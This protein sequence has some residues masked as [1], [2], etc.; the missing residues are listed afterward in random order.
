MNYSVDLDYAVKMD[1]Q[2]PLAAFRDEFYIPRFEGN[3]S[4]QALYFCGNSL[5]LQP[6]CTSEYVNEVLEQW[7]Q[8]GVKGHFEGPYPWLP[9]HELLAEPLAKLVGAKTEEVVAMNSLTTNL[10]LMMVSFFQ[11]TSLRNKIVIEQHAFPSDNYAVASQ[12]I[13]HKLDPASHLITL[14][15]RDD[16]L[17]YTEDVLQLLEQ[18]GDQIVL[19]LLPGI[20]YYTGQRLDLEVITKAAHEKGCLVGADLAHA[21]GNTPLEL[22]QWQVD[23]AVWCH[24]KYLN[25]GPGAVGGCFIHQRHAENKSL[26]RF[27]GW[28][29]H[30][31]QTR[32]DMNDQFSAIASA[33]GWQ[34]SNPPIVS[35][36]AIRASLDVFSKA[37]GMAPLRKKSL[38]LTG[39]FEYLLQQQLDSR[40]TI[41][42]PSNPEQRGCQL[43]L[44][45]ESSRISA[46]DCYQALCDRGVN[47]D[48]REPNVIRATPVPLYNRFQDVYQLVE[49]LKELLL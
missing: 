9:Y 28:W 16:L 25:S 49:L 4:N 5:G 32:F 7:Q 48:W 41:I 42:T 43:S 35:L 26:S 15:H 33:E 46:K 29:G 13:H 23:F 36:A 22:H 38:L 1:Q 44:K 6:R 3:A 20:Q 30:E 10:H 21:V 11:P 2:D 14:R 27:A 19:L 24:Y 37:D 31:K 12:L 45:I 18:Q 17:F 40:V 34:L 39:Y 47:V 8:L